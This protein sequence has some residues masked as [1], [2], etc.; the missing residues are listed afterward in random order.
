MIY[1]TEHL[2][3]LISQ[4]VTLELARRITKVL[5]EKGIFLGWSLTHQSYG[6]GIDTTSIFQ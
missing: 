2:E 3:I 5:D 4:A 6:L 1:A